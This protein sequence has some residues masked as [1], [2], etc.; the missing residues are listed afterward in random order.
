MPSKPPSMSAVAEAAG[1]ARS[2]VSMALRNDRSIPEATRERIRRVAEKL[3]YR[4]NPLVAALMTARS[5]GRPL[6]FKAALAYVVTHRPDESWRE[7]P[8][9]MRFYEGAKARAD[10]L[11]Y[12]L[13]ELATHSP[14]MTARRYTEILRARG[15][16]GLIVAPLPHGETDLGLDVSRFA[17]VGIGL[18]VIT[19]T[20]ER[21]SNDHFQSMILAMQ[22]CH[23]RGYRRIGFVASQETSQRLGHRWLAAFGFGLQSLPGLKKVQPLLPPANEDIE[24]ALPKWCKAH[25]PDVIIFGVFNTRSPYQVPRGIGVVTLAVDDP[26]SDYSGIFQSDLLLGATALDHLVARLNRNQVGSDS[27]QHIHLVEGQWVAGRS[28][29]GPHA[30]NR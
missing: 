30:N 2:T 12:R 29:P 28:A 13:E 17:V 26:T 11:G 27:L 1:V 20:I 10:E 23:E 7:N 15:I 5:T 18:S 19:P 8:V 22:K 24:G 9:F 25:E 3:G 21:I 14:G 6:Q 16:H 4:T